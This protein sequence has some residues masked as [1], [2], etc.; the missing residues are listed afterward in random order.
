MH[1]IQE[2]EQQVYAG[3]L[4]KVIGVYAGRP[5]EGWTKAR[6]EERWGFVDRYVHED[7]GKPL[8]VA[9]DDISGTLTFIRA[10]E[11]TGRYAETTAEQF[12]D[13]W[14]NYLIEGRTV[15]WWGGMGH[16]TEHTAYLRLKHGMK[17]PMSGSIAANGRVVAEQIGAQIFIDGFGLAAPGKPELAAAL[18]RRAASVSHDGEAV[19][20]AV[21]VAGMIAAAFAE[22]DMERLLDLGVSL[23]PADSLIARLHR[24]V[25]G[26]ARQDGDWRATYERIEREY[27]YKKYGGNCHVVPNHAL[28]V[29]AWSYAPDD[30]HRALAI[31]NTAGWDTDCNA[32]N[33][34]CLMGVK[35]GLERIDERYPFREAFA[36]RIFLPTAE[37]TRGVT[38]ALAEALHLARIGRRVMGWPELPPPKRGA[39]LH[40]ALPGALHGFQSEE[41]VWASRG[42]AKV[43]NVESPLAAPERAMRIA[44]RIGPGRVARVSKLILPDIA[45]SGAYGLSAT[46]RLYSGMTVEAEAHVGAGAKGVAQARLFIRHL[47]PETAAGKPVQAVARGQAVE[48]RPGKPALLRLAV[49]HTA[50]WPVAAMGVEIES[51][52][53][54]EGYLY[55]EAIRAIGSPKVAWDVRPIGEDKRDLRFPGWTQDSDVA[56]GGF[57]DGTEPCWHIGKSERRGILATGTAD[58][59]DYAFAARIKIHLAALGGI[60]AR[61]QGL[62]R[63]YALVFVPGAIRLIKRYYGDTVLGEADF[64]WQIDEFHDL[65]LECEG[66]RIRASADGRML[67]DVCDDALGHGGAGLVFE[68]GLIGFRELKVNC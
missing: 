13:A 5:F 29:M 30:F 16:S 19:H 64:D 62:E 51:D 12:G 27:G 60:V 66:P 25:R 48:L 20:A 2:Y 10:M 32:A 41:S 39:W 4:G 45:A 43:E 23:I 65:R 46:P 8:V 49:P 55:L 57:S 63:Y 36:D 59:R 1:D 56:R 11:D 44:Y 53:P 9:D 6:I 61:Y 54:A 22:K 50:G 14:L 38:D 21:V 35:V 3:V 17:A 18:A 47:T 7:V 24:D 31:V 67:F 40:F 15:L 58:W 37:G 26:W 52:E 33:V 28:M 68:K 42:A 34:G